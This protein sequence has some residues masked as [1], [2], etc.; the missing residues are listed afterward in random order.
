[1]PMYSLPSK[2]F[3][4]LRRLLLNYEH[5]NE[6]ALA[7]IVK[8]G[9]VA[10][11]IDSDRYYDFGRE[12]VGHD[13]VIYLGPDAIAPISM[14]VQ[15]KLTDRLRDDLAA[16]AKGIPDEYIKTV[17]IELR[18]ENDF[19]YQT[20]QTLS[21]QPPTNPNS[22][23]FWKPDSIRAFISH[24]D[25]IKRI[26][27]EIANGLEQFGI[28][29]FVA[30]DTIEPT[31]SWQAEMEKALET[32]EVFIALITDD[33]HESVWTNQEVGFARAKGIPV[34]SV[35]LGKIDPRGFIADKQAFRGDPED[36]RD[37][38]EAIYKLLAE[39]LGQRDRIQHALITALCE[40]PNWIETR[41]RFDRMTGLV[42]KLSDEEFEQIKTA[43]KANDQLN[44]AAYLRNS[45]R[46]LK[47]LQRTRGVAYRLTAVGIEPEAPEEEEIPF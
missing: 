5:T 3:T 47:F 35:K 20:A 26:A 44:A 15:E 12:F 2:V 21:G 37:S 40:S 19:L 11:S 4:Y 7:S 25:S 22:L 32:M 31:A 43:Y 39:K 1:V 45:D 41:A 36:L 18:D 13:V 28:S 8:H 38:I 27:H 30:H 33:F 9:E 16:C 6:R 42:N 17:R 10:V 29:S 46:L 24:R 34:I 23:S 14:P